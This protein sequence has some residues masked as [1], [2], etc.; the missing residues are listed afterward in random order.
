MAR[1]I[2]FCLLLSGCPS[3]RVQRRIER[4]Q[5]ESRIAKCKHICLY[6][7][8]KKERPY[9]NDAEGLQTYAREYRQIEREY[10]LCRDGCDSF[11]CD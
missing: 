9:P 10:N 2:I 3:E 6:E 11:L 7:K 5:C 8:D 1:F 4:T